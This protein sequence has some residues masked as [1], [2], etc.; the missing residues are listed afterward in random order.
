[1]E[2]LIELKAG[3]E[4][5]RAVVEVSDDN[6]DLYETDFYQWTQVQA[7]LLSQG[8]WAALDIENLVEEIESLGKQQKQELRNRLGVLIGHL[9]KWEYQPNRRSKSWVATIDLQ[10]DEI[11]HILRENPSLKPYLEEAVAR[12]YKQA[13]AL[14]IKETPLGKRNLPPEIPYTI[15]QILDPQFPLGIDL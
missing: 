1:M 10:R 5:D 12:G 4:S 7:N 9:L 13:I 2:E 3:Q 11:I 8:Q 15:A 14:V 6:L